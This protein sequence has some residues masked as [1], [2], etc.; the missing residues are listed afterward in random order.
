MS[1]VTSMLLP[2][3]WADNLVLAC[4]HALGDDITVK[5]VGS[6]T[7][8]T[9]AD[10]DADLDLQV[11]RIGDRANES[12]TEEDKEKV[13]RNLDLLN[14]VGPV[15]VGNVAIKFSMGSRRRVDLVL[16]RQR[17]E[18]FPRLRGGQDFHENSARIN[19]MFKDY[20]A[21]R[22]AIIGIK[23][24]F[25]GARPKGIL[26]EAIVWRLSKTFVLTRTE[27]AEE[28]FASTLREESFQ[29]F[30]HV[31]KELRAWRNSSFGNNLQHDLLELPRRKREEYEEG[32]EKMKM[33]KQKYLDFALL[34]RYI[35]KQIQMEWTPQKGPLDE[36]VETLWDQRVFRLVKIVEVEG[37]TPPKDSRPHRY[38]KGFGGSGHMRA[39]NRATGKNQ[40][41]WRQFLS[42]KRELST[43]CP[44]IQ[45]ACCFNLLKIH[46]NPKCRRTIV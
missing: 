18:E 23:T 35:W 14:F 15:E 5:M 34:R 3:P 9:A 28:A 19:G 17:Q 2:K 36:Y 22:C 31:V 11:R 7:R 10:E 46:E 44:G 40:N 41:G 37:L 8:G 4:K 13:K 26:L 30:K 32:F 33:V 45:R 20:P 27:Q 29:F 21:A 38:T 25:K 43:Y 12:F 16:Y 6:L 39:R 1:R 24:F 42:T